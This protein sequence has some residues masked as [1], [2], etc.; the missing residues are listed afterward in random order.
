MLYR[1]LARGRMSVVAP[2]TGVE[3]AAVPVI[4]GL[5]SGERP[6]AGAYVGI[7]LALLAV[8][9]VSSSG[10]T[11]SDSRRAG[12]PE[13]LGAGLAFGIFFIALDQ[14]GPD[15]GIWPLIGARISSISLTAGIAVLARTKLKPPAGTMPAIAAAGILDVT[16]NIFYLVAVRRGF[17]S[18][19]AV[20]TSMYPAATVALAR[21][22]LKE[23]LAPVQ[24]VGIAL[25][26]AA[27]ILI[28]VG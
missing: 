19:V 1:G 21:V 3:A 6:S 17:L 4:F 28:G 2:I 10:S 9:L 22:V 15:T 12:L 16:A 18:L 25:A 11:G 7:A 23:R 20:L 5:A 27:V 26:L 8:V 13:A 24:L 14:A